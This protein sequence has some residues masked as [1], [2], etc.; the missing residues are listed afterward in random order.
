MAAEPRVPVKMVHMDAEY[1]DI[2]AYADLPPGMAAEKAAKVLDKFSYR[3]GVAVWGAGGTGA[4]LAYLM[5]S[6]ARRK[7]G[8][9]LSFIVMPFSWE[10]R[11][12]DPYTLK[13]MDLYPYVLIEND[14]LVRCYPHLPVLRALEKPFE[15]L[16]H[17]IEALGTAGPGCLRDL[18]GRAGVG[19]GMGVGREGAVVSLRSAL[20]SPFVHG[21]RVAFLLYRGDDDASIERALHGLNHD[22]SN[23]HLLPPRRDGIHETFILTTS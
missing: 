13:C 7:G 5:L 9:F 20:S 18:S 8:W 23:V 6:L 10:G 14:I 12:M 17:L 2:L 16:G 1:E 3:W 15:Y 21:D 11:D 4:R 19:Y 22:P